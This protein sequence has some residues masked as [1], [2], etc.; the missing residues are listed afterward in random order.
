MALN[1]YLL[2]DV[3]GGNTA[4]PDAMPKKETKPLGGHSTS[5]SNAKNPLSRLNEHCQKNC[6]RPPNYDEERV[7]EQEFK[8]RV[9]YRGEAHEGPIR[10]GKNEAKRA[11]AQI[12]ID[13]FNID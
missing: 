3:G 9:T 10:R 11:A 5:Q 6:Y 8:Y 4:T 13:K 7:G 2:F 12:M 1:N